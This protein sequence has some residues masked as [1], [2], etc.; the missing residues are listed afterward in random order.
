MK[1]IIVLLTIVALMM[2]MLAAFALPGFATSDKTYTCFQGPHPVAT[3]LT[4]EQA[5]EFL[6][7]GLPGGLECQKNK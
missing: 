7:S 5:K 6:A 2:V 1:R 4:K 3:D